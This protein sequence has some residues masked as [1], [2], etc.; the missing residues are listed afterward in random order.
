M[1]KKKIIQNHTNS[2][3]SD[4]KQKGLTGRQL[5]IISIIQ[6]T[7]TYEAAIKK[8]GISRGTFYNLIRNE[9]F[10]AELARQRKE[11]TDHALNILKDACTEA[12]EELRNLIKDE[13]ASIRLRASL[14]VIDYTVKIKEVEDFAERLGKLEE[15][16]KKQKK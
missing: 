12:V 7:R 15:L 8:A 9:S 14:G 13:S 10:K 11:I 1:K 16:I 3:T 2:D 5:E 6:S 4:K